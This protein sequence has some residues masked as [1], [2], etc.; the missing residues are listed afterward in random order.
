[1]KRMIDLSPSEAAKIRKRQV[2]GT[3]NEYYDDDN[4]LCFSE[5]EYANWKPRK[6]GRKVKSKKEQ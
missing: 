3:M 1:M 5:E 2:N 4:Y 6:C